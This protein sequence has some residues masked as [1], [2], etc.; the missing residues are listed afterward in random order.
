MKEQTI[1]D[2][3]FEKVLSIRPNWVAA[4]VHMDEKA[5]TVHIEILYA[6]DNYHCPKCGKESKLY[7][8]RIRRLRHLDTCDYQTILEVKVPRIKCAEHGVQQLNVD[9]AEKHSL[10]TEV[11]E[12][13]VIE[14]LKTMTTITAARQMRIG[15]DAIDNIKQRAVKRGLLRREKIGVK[16]L[17]IDETSYQKGHNYVTI[18]YDKNSGKVL[19]VL[20]NRDAETVKEWFLGQEIAYFGFLESISMDMSR[21]FISAVKG[22]FPEWERQ[23]CFDRFHISQLFNKALDKVRRYELVLLEKTGEGNPLKKMRFGFLINS[24]RTDNRSGKRR[25]FLE[26]SRLNLKTAR[27]W[28]IKETASLLWEY[29]YMGVA[30]K[31]W[32]SLLWWMSH[33]RIPEMI[34]VGKTI[35]DHLW[36]ILNAVRMKLTN[37]VPESKNNIIQQFKKM[38]Y[39]FR[40]DEPRRKH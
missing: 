31:N 3:F 18:V 4:G 38:A 12:N 10:Y 32:K 39:G 30:E 40:N 5:K 27:A 34:Q 16:D 20:D 8:H 21:S 11:F 35:K 37:A 9:F 7:D 28:R 33:C 24:S 22:L 19:D 2:E 23:I 29:E 14:M 25:R 17:G 6:N 26:V 36:G 1:L 13:K 15:W